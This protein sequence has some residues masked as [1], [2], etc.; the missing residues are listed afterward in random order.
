MLTMILLVFAFVLA[1]LATWGFGAPR[2]ALGWASLAC[3][4]LSLLLG[5][6]GLSAHF[7]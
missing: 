6:S 5:G 3:Y 4:Y 2:W 7:K 1:C